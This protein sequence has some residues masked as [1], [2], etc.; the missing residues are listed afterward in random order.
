MMKKL[1]FIASVA[2]FFASCQKEMST[3]QDA[4]ASSNK[5]SL[6]RSTNERKTSPALQS[7]TQDWMKWVFSRPVSVSPFSD[8]DGS[9]QSLGQ[10]YQSGVFMLAGG[11]GPDLISRTVTI[12]LSQYQSVF[13]P[14]VN[15]YNYFD[16]CDRSFAPKNGQ[17]PLAYN[18]SLINEAFNGPRELTLLWD[19]VSLLSTKQKDQRANSGIFDFTIDPSWHDGC[20]AP[21][22]TFYV[23][24]YWAL[25]PL[26]IGTHQLIVGGDFNLRK[27]KWEFSNLVYYTINVVP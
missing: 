21:T 23:D 24:G 14:L 16:D 8:N 7:L 27:L 6:V 15:I 4:V 2:L 17:N 22:T 1:I 12:S 11:S 26:T 18:Q 25:I 9:L 20:F 10:P 13:V 5:N 3:K 19:G